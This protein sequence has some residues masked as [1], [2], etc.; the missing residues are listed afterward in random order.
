MVTKHKYF[1]A[2]NTDRQGFC[3]TGGKPPPGAATHPCPDSKWEGRVFPQIVIQLLSTRMH[4]VL[5]GELVLV[6]GT[7]GKPQACFMVVTHL[8][9]HVG[10][11]LA[12]FVEIQQGFLS[13]PHG[14]SLRLM[15]VSFSSEKGQQFFGNLVSRVWVCMT[16]HG[17][18]FVSV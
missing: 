5:L 13:Q 12:Y 17:C 6:C 14:A 9:T 18:V 4:A 10:S 3:V 15:T 1:G 7:L 16:L 8:P 11:Q 2:E